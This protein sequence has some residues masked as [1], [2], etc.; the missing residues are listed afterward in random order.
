MIVLIG[1]L[2]TALVLFSSVVGGALGV[3]IL[4]LSAAVVVLLLALRSFLRP[5]AFRVALQ[6]FP[7]S[8]SDPRSMFAQT[9]RAAPSGEILVSYTRYRQV[10]QAIVVL[11]AILGALLAVAFVTALFQAGYPMRPFRQS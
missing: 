10:Y 1:I 6:H 11:L 4:T 8:I 5:E 7:G 3:A 2:L 9:A